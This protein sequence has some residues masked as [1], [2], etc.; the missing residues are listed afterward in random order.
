MPTLGNPLC[1]T[2]SGNFRISQPE[3]NQ[4]YNIAVYPGRFNI[5]F[6]TIVRLK[7]INQG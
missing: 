7:I 3:K 4:F 1:N 6:I 2:L 5:F